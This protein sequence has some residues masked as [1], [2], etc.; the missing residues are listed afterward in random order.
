MPSYFQVFQFLYLSFRDCS[1]CTNHKWHH[2]Y[3]HVPYFVCS[4]A[5]SWYLCFFLLSFIFT[6]WSAGTTKPTIRQVL[7]HQSGRLAEIRWS[8]CILLLFFFFLDYEFF[9]PAMM[10]FHRCF[11][12]HKI[13][14]T[15]LS[16][17]TNF[18]NPVV[19]MVSILLLISCSSSLLLFLLLFEFFTRALAES[20]NDTKSPQ[21]SKILLSILAD[22]SNV[23]VWMVSTRPNISKSSSP[24]T[25]PLVAV[26]RA[27]I[28]TGIT[29]TFMLHSFFNSLA[30]SRYLSFFSL[31]VNFT[32]WSTGA[33]KSTIRQVLFSLLNI[34]K[35]GCPARIRCSVCI[36]KSL[37]S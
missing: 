31:S 37:R 11:E 33:A 19:W 14:R 32:L 28:K 23:V 24:C 10:V 1:K 15:L 20:L 3:L 35:P 29:V 25:N 34:F 21:I 26:P 6:L 5:S 2:C 22:F 12:W 7:Y 8:I 16:I 18:N 13:S 4:Q 36:S 17:L 9:T 30:R 27:S